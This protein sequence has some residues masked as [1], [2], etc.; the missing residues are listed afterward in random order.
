MRQRTL[1]PNPTY[2]GV[3]RV[4]GGYQY[5]SHIS[6]I[7]TFS[8]HR[9]LWRFCNLCTPLSSITSMGSS[10]PLNRTALAFFAASKKNDFYELRDFLSVVSITR[11][12]IPTSSSARLRTI[13]LPSATVNTPPDCNGVFFTLRRCFANCWAYSVLPRSRLTWIISAVLVRPP[14]IKL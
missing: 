6:R 1:T 9:Q 8:T 13:A 7:T 11:G 2:W 5:F 3:A 12:A 14:L 10:W 4:V